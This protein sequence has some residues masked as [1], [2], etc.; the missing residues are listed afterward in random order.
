MHLQVWAEN[1][2][3]VFYKTAFDGEFQEIDMQRR[4]RGTV[5]PEELPA[6]RNTLR[7]IATEKCKDLQKLLRWVPESFHYFYHNIP[8]IM[9]TQT[10][11]D[12]EG[13]VHD[14]VIN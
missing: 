13:Y 9:S 11:K 2:G 4:T 8:Q 10:E 5:W 3:T 12:S 6:I 7:P 1:S 14:V